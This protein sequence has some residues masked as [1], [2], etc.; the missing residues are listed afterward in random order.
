MASPGLR[1][2]PF[3]RSPSS[4][5]DPRVLGRRTRLVAYMRVQRVQRSGKCSF[6]GDFRKRFERGQGV[7]VIGIMLARAE[8]KS[9][10]VVRIYDLIVTV[11]KTR[12]ELEAIGWSL[13]DGTEVERRVYFLRKWLSR[14]KI[15]GG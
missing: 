11:D 10:I 1:F 7:P 9:R 13:V 5:S 6:T 3:R 4:L 8:T 14:R 12:L 2:E 15:G